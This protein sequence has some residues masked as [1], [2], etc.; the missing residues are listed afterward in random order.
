MIRILFFFILTAS[1][2]GCIM[3]QNSKSGKFDRKKWASSSTYRYEIIKSKDF[4]VLKGKS[5]RYVRGLLGK[6]D[7]VQDNDFIYCLETTTKEAKTKLSKCDGSSVVINFD[8][9]NPD[10]VTIIKVEPLYDK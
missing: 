4:P 5:K 10:N 2:S 8:K 1:F 6:P 9:R 3:S 7:F